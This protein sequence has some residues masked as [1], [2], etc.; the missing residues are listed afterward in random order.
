MLVGAGTA[1]GLVVSV[2]GIFA[3]RAAAPPAPGMSLY[4]P[5]T[6]PLTMLAIAVFMAIVGLAAAAL[7]AWRAA[8]M[9]P[10]TALRHD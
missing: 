4:R 7:P 10:L 5:T 1:A 3:L 8:R 6:D 2:I 9:D